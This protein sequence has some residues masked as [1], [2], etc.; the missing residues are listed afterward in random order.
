MVRFPE[1]FAMVKQSGFN[2]PL[3][4]HFEYP[5]GGANDGKTKLSIPQEEVFA[6]MTRDVRQLRSYLKE[7]G[8]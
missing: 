4:I 3:Q 8:I 2:G 7:A 5:L 1:F 6:A